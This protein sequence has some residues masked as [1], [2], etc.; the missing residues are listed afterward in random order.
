M[1]FVIE[2]RGPGFWMKDVNFPLTVAFI[3][4]C[5][6]IVDIQDMEPNS[7]EFHDT[8]HDFRFGLEVNGGWFESHSVNVGDRIKLPPALRSSDCL[9]ASARRA[10]QPLPLRLS[11]DPVSMVVK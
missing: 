9:A 11:R 3:D 5:G 10:S 1:L 7:L 6:K 4:R 8:Q 2:Q